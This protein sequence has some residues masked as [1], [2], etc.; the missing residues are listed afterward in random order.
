MILQC[1]LTPPFKPCSAGT[2]YNSSLCEK[3]PEEQ[4]NPT[5]K[6]HA[7][8]LTLGSSDKRPSKQHLLAA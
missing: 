6:E 5:V 3:P 8:L 1:S 4:K 2:R 7:Q